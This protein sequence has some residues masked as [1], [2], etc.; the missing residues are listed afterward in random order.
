MGHITADLGWYSVISF[1]IAN[2]K[3]VIGDRGY[4]VLLYLCG[5]FLV[6][7]GIWFVKGI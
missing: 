3:R 4:K 7:F 1:A 6:V 2:G 5:A